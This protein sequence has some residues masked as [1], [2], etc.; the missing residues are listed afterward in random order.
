MTDLASRPDRWRKSS[1]SGAGNDCVEVA[2]AAHKA[3]VRDSKNPS[4]GALRFAR[5]AWDGFLTE[6]QAVASPR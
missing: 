6:P 2:L 5:A 4:G 3:A 1:Y